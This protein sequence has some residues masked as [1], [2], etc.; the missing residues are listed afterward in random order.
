MLRGNIDKNCV[1]SFGDP[2]LAMILSSALAVA[3]AERCH[4]SCVLDGNQPV[5][6][7]AA[8]QQHLACGAEPAW[9]TAY[10]REASGGHVYR[11]PRCLRHHQPPLPG[12]VLGSCRSTAEDP[13]HSE[14]HLR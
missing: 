9:T 12:R 11:L 2:I 6:R 10:S 5:S 13:P 7:P 14:G 1:I 3:A 4:D 8:T